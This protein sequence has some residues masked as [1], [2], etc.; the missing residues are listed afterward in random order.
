MPTIEEI[1]LGK[2]L[3]EKP[4]LEEVPETPQ[5]DSGDEI[6][7]PE[8]AMTLLEATDV[9]VFSDP[10]TVGPVPPRTELKVLPKLEEDPL[11]KLAD[12]EIEKNKVFLNTAM[13]A[14]ASIGVS[15]PPLEPPEEGCLVQDG[16]WEDEPVEKSGDPPPPAPEITL[17]KSM[18][19]SSGRVVLIDGSNMAMRCFFPL[20]DMCRSDGHPS[21]LL[22]GMLK[23]IRAVKAATNAMPILVWD[24]IR[25]SARK[26]QV[27]ADYK[28]N[29][30]QSDIKDRCF[31]QLDEV[32]EQLRCTGIPQVRMEEEEADD[33]IASLACN[34][35]KD[36]L[37]FVFSNDNDFLQLVDDSHIIVVKMENKDFEFYDS[38]KV[39]E[40]MGVPP[41]RVPLFR[42]LRGDKSDNL[43][44]IHRFPSKVIV[45]LF[46]TY[47]GL[48]DLFSNPEENFKD[49][50]DFQR[51][52]ISGFEQQARINLDLMTLNRTLDPEL[53][54]AN[55][56]AEYLR[57]VFEEMEFNS[58]L[59]NFETWV[60]KLGPTSGFMKVA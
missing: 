14:V 51:T 29:R 50:T 22:Y 12:E 44:G 40:K 2:P 39:E 55:F 25:G 26:K 46:Q 33:V 18:T 30:G 42:S 56:D 24:G 8:E 45:S 5:K 59:Q 28:G 20:K 16:S 3:E 43:P 7:S 10:E 23:S 38:E 53:Q 52:G 6:V 17:V 36:S 34:T 54:V 60:E 27:Y 11:L 57:H 21:G 13:E 31:A 9:F 37:V 41:E 19:P 1:L 35:F 32:R 49:L 48:D 4:G 15:S 47:S 58:Y